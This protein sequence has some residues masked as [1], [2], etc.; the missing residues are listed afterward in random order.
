MTKRKPKEE[1]NPRGRPT[2]Y[3]PDHSVQA[4]KLC[5]LGLTDVEIAF[6]FEINPLTFYRWKHAHPEFCKA[7]TRGKELADDVVEQ[8]LYR[9][10]VGYAHEAVKIFM[11]AGA[12][13][14]VYAPFVERFPPDPGAAKLWLTNRRPETW[15][16]KQQVEH[17]GSVTLESLVAEATKKREGG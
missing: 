15:R 16:D 7:V 2:D 4:K 13:K 11:P 10:A 3:T 1:Q 5:T 8:S 6:F 17:S 14:P 9:R 12:D